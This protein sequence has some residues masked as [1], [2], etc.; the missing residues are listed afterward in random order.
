MPVCGRVDILQDPAIQRVFLR[1][2]LPHCAG[3]W[4]LLAPEMRLAGMR[5]QWPFIILIGRTLIHAAMTF[6]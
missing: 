1:Q 5:L 6:P 3:I 4:R 2:E